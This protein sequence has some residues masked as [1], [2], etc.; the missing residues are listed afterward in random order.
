MTEVPD[1][2]GMT[3]ALGSFDLSK[4]TLDSL[5]LDMAGP[6]LSA[7]SVAVDLDGTYR[8][9]VDGTDT[10][11]DAAGIDELD[12]AENTRYVI[13]VASVV[14]GLGNVSG[15]DDV[16]A[17]AA[18]AAFSVGAEFDESFTLHSPG[19][20]ADPVDYCVI[21]EAADVARDNEGNPAP[22]TASVTTT[23]TVDWTG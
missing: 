5:H 3:L 13:E 17:V 22:N 1:A 21:V 16:D 2:D 23:F 10:L 11:P 4:A 7:A 12:E 6:N 18:S 20:T 15:A 9:V 19:L 14:D 8:V